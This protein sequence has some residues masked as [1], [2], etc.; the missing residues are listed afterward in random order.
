MLNILNVEYMFICV[1]I[2]A[3]ELYRGGGGFY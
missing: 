1:K 2:N 3:S